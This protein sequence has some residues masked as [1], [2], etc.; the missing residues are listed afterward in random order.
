MGTRLGRQKEKMPEGDRSG[1]MISVGGIS[2]RVVL[3]EGEESAKQ[4]KV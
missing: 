4:V 2:N 3:R 1:L